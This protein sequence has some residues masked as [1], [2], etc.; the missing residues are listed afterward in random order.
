MLMFLVLQGN[1][2]KFEKVDLGTQNKIL[3]HA[4][5]GLSDYRSLL[6][7]VPDE[8][9]LTPFRSK[10]WTKSRPTYHPWY[11]SEHYT[12]VMCLDL[13]ITRGIH[14]NITLL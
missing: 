11:P 3:E 2:V 8:L 1:K 7:L 14:L 13:P 5:V 9:P 10:S 4:V 12:T 6:L